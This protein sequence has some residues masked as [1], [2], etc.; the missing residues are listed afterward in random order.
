MSFVA[1]LYRSDWQDRQDSV[2]LGTCGLR[3]IDNLGGAVSQGVELQLAASVFENLK[4]GLSAAYNDSSFKDTVVLGSVPVVQKGDELDMPPWM[5]T[6]SL[7]YS[8]LAFETGRAYVHL[9]GQYASGHSVS[10]G[11]DTDFPESARRPKSLFASARVGMRF[12]AWDVS[13][14]ASNLFDTHRI[15]RADAVAS[16]PIDELPRP[17]TV[18][19]TIRST[20]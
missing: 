16:E 9:D 17:R 19:V 12:G 1:S 11:A 20:F 18:G 6:A 15:V 5:V 10:V 13:L 3:Y 14:F 7:D 4:L 2:S 8:L